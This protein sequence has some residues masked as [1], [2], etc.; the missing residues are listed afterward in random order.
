MATIRLGWSTPPTLS[1][2]SDRFLVGE[3]GHLRA[4]PPSCHLAGQEGFEP[5][6]R[7]FGDRCSTVRATGL[8]GCA[9]ASPH[10]ASLCSWC[11]RHRGQYLDR[12]SLSWVFFLFLVVV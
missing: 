11:L 1:M 9:H 12:V 6:T 5:P 4:T 8:S 7:G 2:A 10:F 3:R